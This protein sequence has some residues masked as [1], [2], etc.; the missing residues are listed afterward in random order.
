MPSKR[1][2][3]K[4]HYAIIIIFKNGSIQFGGLY[5][6]IGYFVSRLDKNL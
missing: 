2:F 1:C 6:A 4:K 3:I 5:M